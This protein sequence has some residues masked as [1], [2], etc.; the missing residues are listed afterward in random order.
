LSSIP[1]DDLKKSLIGLAGAIGIF[2]VAYGLIQGIN[3]AASKLTTNKKY[4]F[5]GFWAVGLST[6][7]LVMAVAVKA[8]S[9][10]DDKQVWNATVILGTMLGFITA[11][12][13][14][15]ALISKIPGQ[16]KITANLFGMSASLLAIVGALTLLQLFSINDLQ[17]SLGKMTAILL[18]L[19]AIQ[20]LFGV[21]ARIGGG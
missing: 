20:G 4:G 13:V 19:A 15:A 10:I 8:I 14:L 17:S 12:Q 7:L 11:Y 5:F 9:K 6:A 21:A 16:Q 18:V 2:V 3:V 1:A